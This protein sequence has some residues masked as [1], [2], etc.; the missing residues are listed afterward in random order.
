MKDAIAYGIADENKSGADIGLRLED[1]AQKWGNVLNAN[2]PG[3]QHSGFAVRLLT[4]RTWISWNAHESKRMYKPYS[5]SNATES[6]RLAVL[7]IIVSPDTPAQVAAGAGMQASSSVEHVVLRSEDKK[8]AIQP[9]T[10]EPYQVDAK[11]A[12]GGNQSY[13]GVVAIFNMA[14][15]DKLRKSSDK[16]QF[17]VTVI[18]EQG[19]EKNFTVKQKHFE[20]L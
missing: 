13:N 6:D 2:N 7:R 4:P 19:K 9:L 1:S 15:V 17:L 11:N 10:I 20:H 12:M 16:E 8:D 18:G 3:A 14:D 5:V